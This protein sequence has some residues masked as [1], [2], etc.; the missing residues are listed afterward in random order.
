[1]PDFDFSTLITDRSPA[2]L[3]LLRD[4]LSTPM[5]D[6]TAEQLAEF[7]LARSKGAYNYTDLNRVTACMDYLNERL[8]G[9]GYSTGYQ[10]IEI[11]HKAQ[12][13]LPEGYTELAYIE[14]TGT[15]YIDTG[16]KPNQDTRVVMKTQLTADAST[17]WVFGARNSN[18]DG[19]IG[20]FWYPNTNTW[21]ADYDGNSQRYNFPGSIGPLD[22]IE[23]DYNKNEVSLNNSSHSFSSQAF[24]NSNT[25]AL[26]AINT[27]GTVSSYS[28]A[29]IYS[30]T[31][32][33][34]GTLIRDYVPC[35]DPSGEVGLYDQVN[36]VF[37]GNAGTGTFAHGPVVI[38]TPPAP[39]NLR[40]TGKTLESISLAWD[41]VEAADGYKLYRDGA[42]IATQATTSYTDTGLLPS[43]SHSYQ[44]LAYNDQGDGTLSES[45]SMSTEQ[46]YYVVTPVFT[47]AVFTQNPVTINTSVLLSVAVEDQMII[48]QPEVFQSNEIYSGE[49]S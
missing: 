18:T 15:Q 47:S 6:W 32:Y 37:Y 46:A 24:Q 42:L 44:V 22:L 14:S 3:E 38:T 11:P 34:N 2:D 43:E 45:V 23:I 9:Y 4:M 8:T 1:M 13:R 31:I 33:D 49:A 35:S 36:G 21:S 16:F 40:Q 5:S 10:K 28:D 29:K 17:S 48:L 39:Q 25:L 41:A 12:S 19:T 7:N 20:V 27:A 26:L 30:C